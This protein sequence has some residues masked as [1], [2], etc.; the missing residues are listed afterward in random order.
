MA[1]LDPY[2][3]WQHIA[4]KLSAANHD[5]C[6]RVFESQLAQPGYARGRVRK[7]VFSRAEK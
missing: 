7:A 5:F 3:H 2:P 1:Q 6:V 4:S